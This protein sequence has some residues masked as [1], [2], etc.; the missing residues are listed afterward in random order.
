MSNDIKTE[1]E[2]RNKI[3]SILDKFYALKKKDVKFIPGESKVNYAAAVYD[4]KEIKSMVATLLD[5]WFGI[6]KNALRFENEFRNYLGVKKAIFVNSGSSANLLAL[7]AFFSKQLKDKDRFR[8]GDEVIT[9]ALTFPT[10][11]NPIIQYNLKPII[12]DVELGTYNMKLDNLDKVITDKTK[13]IM[14]P[15]TLGNPNDMD[16]IMEVAKDNGLKVIEDACDALGSKFAGRYVGTFGEF[17]TFSFYPAH[18]ITTGEGGMIIT[19]DKELGDIVQSMRDWGR[20]C[21]IPICEPI[22]CGDQECPRAIQNKSI[23]LEGLPEDYDK[24][25]SYTNIGYNLKPIE[26]QGAMG[27]EQLK[28]LPEFIEKRNS[29]FKIL[30]DDFQKYKDYF[31]LP[32]W[33]KNSEPSWFAFPLTIKKNTKFKRKHIMEWYLKNNIEAKLLFSGNILKHPAYRD[34]EFKIGEPITNSKYCMHNTFFLGVYPGLSEE[35]LDFIVTKTKDFL[36]KY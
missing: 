13:A 9:P 4:E 19:N 27:R 34:F 33:I 7:G 32:K 21:V 23:G 16:Y 24:R 31:I 12:L 8:A 11:L 26:L 25:Y 18:H 29:N 6:S 28:K 30:Y 36:N 3:N 1:E 20:A 15:H 17:G 2:L 10:T 35:K 22:K 14:L 5:G